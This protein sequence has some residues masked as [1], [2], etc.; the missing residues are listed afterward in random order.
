MKSQNKMRLIR[1]RPVDLFVRFFK[2]FLVLIYRY[3]FR[4]YGKGFSFDP[5]GNYSFENISVGND[6]S[7]GYRA[8]IIAARSIIEI[9]SHVM[10]GPEVIIR[11]GNHRIDVIGRYMKDVGNHEKRERDD[12]GVII[13]DDVWIG[14]RAIILHGVTIGRGSV[15]AAGSVVTRS[16]PPYAVVAGVPSRVI[17]FRWPPETIMHHE[18]QLYPITQRLS[19]RDLQDMQ[20]IAGL[21]K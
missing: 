19:L 10:F 5:L 21:N 4:S 15:V 1:N 3:R 14:T 13:N 7:L 20:K 16:V 12:L 8:Q 11:G 17:K 18:E 9:G 2:S 6:V